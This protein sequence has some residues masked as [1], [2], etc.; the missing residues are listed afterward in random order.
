MLINQRTEDVVSHVEFVEYTG[1]WPNLCHGVLT[2]KIDDKI[3]K[4]G[5]GQEHPKF[6]ITGGHCTMQTLTT[7]E[8]TIDVLKLP[9]EFR[10][11]AAEIDNV[12][13]TNVEYGCCGGCR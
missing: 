7:D 4:F 10:K 3:Q 11:Y 13:N 2:L 12:F 6:W 5:N 9:E 8:W 1:K